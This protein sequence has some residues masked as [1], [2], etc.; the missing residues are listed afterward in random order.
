MFVS[1]IPT[2]VD[3]L[4]AKMKELDSWL[5][6]G[7]YE[8]VSDFGQKTIDTRWV[9]TLKKL[10]DGSEVPKARLVAREMLE[11]NITKRDKVIRI[12]LSIAEFF[13]WKIVVKTAFLQSDKLNRDV[14]IRPPLESEE[15]NVLW[16]LEKP[17]YGLK[18][19]SKHWF[20]KVLQVFND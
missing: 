9:L 18:I 11:K 6:L 8:P 2:N 16:R 5:G 14:F 7:V 3:F 17:V 20:S 1:E 10:A 15:Q 13:N 4:P 12:F 19:A